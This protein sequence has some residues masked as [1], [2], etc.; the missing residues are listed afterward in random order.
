[1]LAIPSMKHSFANEMC[2]MLLPGYYQHML[3]NFRTTQHHITLSQKKLFIFCKIHLTNSNYLFGNQFIMVTT[4]LVSLY[5]TIKLYLGHYRYG[6]HNSTITMCNLQ[7]ID[8]RWNGA[9]D[10]RS[11]GSLRDA[12]FCWPEND[13]G[14]II[15]LYIRIY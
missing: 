3:E 6:Y 12:E 15:Y 5:K 10:W 14:K 8:H 1:M 2:K 9:Q 4:I 13:G 7:G 11:R